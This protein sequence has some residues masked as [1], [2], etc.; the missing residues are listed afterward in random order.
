V[1]ERCNEAFPQWSRRR[2]LQGAGALLA[3]RLLPFAEA[4]AA[5]ESTPQ[6]TPSISPPPWFSQPEA[7]DSIESEYDSVD[8]FFRAYADEMS[9]ANSGDA[10]GLAL[11]NQVIGLLD[12]DPPS[13]QR[14]GRLFASHRDAT[15]DPN[16]RQIAAFGE[17]Y[18]RFL[19][20]GEYLHAAPVWDH[21]EAIRYVKDPG[22]TGDIRTITLGRSAISVSETSLIKTQVDRVTRDWLLAFHATG[23]PW[24]YQ[25]HDLFKSHEGSRISDLVRDAG[26]KVVPIW[27]MK[28]IRIG[29]RWYAPDGA[30]RPSFE[31]SPD[32]I[33]NYPTTIVV[34]DQT[35][36]VNDTHG[37]SALA[38]DALD[39][40][41]VLGCGD[42]PGKMDAAY[43]L[44]SRGV[45]VYT[46]TDRFMGLL[47]G[48]RTAG[49]IVGSAPI[50]KTET[51][52]EI[53]NQPVTIDASETIV[54]SNASAR[55]PLQYYDTPYRYFTLL[56]SYMGK[57]LRLIDVQV[58]EYGKATNVVDTA[59]RIGARVLGIRVKSAQ[60]HDGVANWLREDSGRRAVL[61]HTAAYRDGYP[62]FAEFPTQT[63]F[64]DIKPVFDY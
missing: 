15:D 49:T 48:A 24:N 27:G 46:P 16:E 4:R 57:P 59:R 39:A 56:G 28:A 9:A 29:E 62:L 36:I 13:I 34:D 38:W 44:A 51:G 20:T 61:F 17:K 23:R 41:L 8:E 50:K 11:A 6:K 37:I 47:I 40:N 10:Y 2:L 54:V 7:M 58:T 64:G 43:Y 21:V 45:H 31:I 26:A 22:P 42:H 60:E 25:P 55:Y 5:G 63:S 52:A 35:V 53:G 3:A 19:L 1:C 14:A 12:N 30:G 32:K 18:C 33:D